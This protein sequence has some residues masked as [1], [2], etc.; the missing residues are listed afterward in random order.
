MLKTFKAEILNEDLSFLCSKWILDRTPH[1]FADDRSEYLRWKETLSQ[2]LSIDSKSIVFTGSSSVGF[3]LNPSKKFKSFDENS[4]IDLAIVSDLHFDISW[5]YLRNM[6]TRRF[7]LTIRQ[8]QHIQEHVTRLIYWGTIA[9]DK[10]LEILPFGKDWELVLLEL[11]KHEPINGKEINIRIYK[12]FESLRQY[13]IN[14]L[15]N[16]SQLSIP[17]TDTKL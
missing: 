12:D 13:Q 15:K 1:I 17:V 4:D 11:A 6:G 3:S 16:I 5:K 10:I 8:K 2:K 9:T 7:D 14:N